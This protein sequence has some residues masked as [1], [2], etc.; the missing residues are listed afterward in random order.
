MSEENA[1]VFDIEKFAVHDGPGIRSVVF[2]KGCPLRCLWC[3]NPESQ[4]MEPELLFN[5]GKCTSCGQC[6]AVCPESCHVIRP[7]GVHE[8]DRSR[9]LR[10]GRCAE[11]CPSEALELVGRKMSVSEVM[12]D[13]MKDQVFYQ[14]SGGGVTLSGGEP[15]AH[16]A[17]T[18]ALLKAAKEAGLHT[19][20]ETSGFVSPERISALMP[21]VDLWLWDVK[22]SPAKHEKLTGVPADPILSNLASLNDSGA[23]IILRCPL[24][25][26]VN[27][28]DED[29]R[30]I[31]GLANRFGQVRRIDLEPY[32]PMG[33]GKSLNLG[34]TDVFHSSF[35]SEED[36]ER[37]RRVISSLTKT[38]V[39]L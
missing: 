33:E 2:I 13:V 17:F 24:V 6:A 10:C 36:K 1:I 16:F 26:G 12:D 5:A 8:F 27:D 19:A 18:S 31:A 39:H 3:H 7:D 15:L 22:A 37:W 30:H 21:L 11:V 29:L 34:R 23:E 14:S 38:E 4:A 9:C 20:V 35:A 28:G 25:P 32:H